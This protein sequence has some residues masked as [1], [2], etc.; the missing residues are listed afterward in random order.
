MRKPVRF[1]VIYLFV[2]ITTYALGFTFLPETVES[3][4][5]QWL[6]GGFLL[7]YFVA[8]PAF[9]WFCV[10]KV[11][12]QKKWKIIIPLSIASVVARY[13][14]PASL[15]SYF[16]FLSWARYPVIALLLIIELAVVYHVVSML[17]KSRKLS[18]DPRI[19][20][21]IN[22]IDDD[23]KKRELALMMA[24]EPASWYYAMP[25]FTKK[26]V[27]ILANLSLLSAK[28]WHFGLLLAALIVLTW[29]SYTLLALWSELAAMIV[30][31]VLFY[32]IV[33][34]TASH[35]ISRRFSMYCHNGYLVINATFFNLLLAPLPHVKTCE[36]GSW[37]CDKEH[38]KVGRGDTANIKLTFSSPVYWFTLMGTFCERPTEVYLCVDNPDEMAV[39][40]SK[41]RG[42][43]A[44]PNDEKQLA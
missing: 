7:A 2:A 15:A 25:R 35:R 38:L 23:D 17:W 20:A 11:G 36:I 13:S 4:F 19:N 24:S 44:V 41:A 5:D 30:S 14:M 8:L 28:R 40:F 12:E 31:S 43:T 29:S 22:H 32:S 16:E 37:V 9:F 33:S 21:L 1:R 26:H 3:R 42:Q 27:P 10:I 18:G 39:Q 34:L 6:S